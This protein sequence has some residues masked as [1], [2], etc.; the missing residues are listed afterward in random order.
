MFLSALRITWVLP[1][2]DRLATSSCELLFRVLGEKVPATGKPTGCRLLCGD[3]RM[4]CV[5]PHSPIAKDRARPTL[6]G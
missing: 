1:P 3:L 2:F 5:A 4:V 6:Y